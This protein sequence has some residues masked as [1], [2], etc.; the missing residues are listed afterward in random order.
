MIT[1]FQR[2]KNVIEREL[3]VG[4]RN[5]II[6]PYGEYGTIAKQI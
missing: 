2:I 3:N 4:K 1:D 5:F 6:Y